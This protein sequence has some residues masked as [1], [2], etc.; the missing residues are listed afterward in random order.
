[1]INLPV[2]GDINN[3]DF[4]YAHLV[5]K[6]FGGVI[7]APFNF[8]DKL[9]GTEDAQLEPIGFALTGSKLLREEQERLLTIAKVLKK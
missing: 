1:M 9:L 2:R 5:W 8:L 3:S 7:T 6:A 4:S